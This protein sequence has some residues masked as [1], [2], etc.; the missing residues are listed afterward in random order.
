MAVKRATAE[1]RAASVS[2]D[3]G[4][5]PHL[6]ESEIKGREKRFNAGKL[7]TKGSNQQLLQATETKQPYRAGKVC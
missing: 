1:L 6:F 5:P 7:Y 4:P 3:P 2:P